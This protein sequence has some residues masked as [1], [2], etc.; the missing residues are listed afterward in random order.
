M[1][2]A[3]AFL[4]EHAGAV[5]ALAGPCALVAYKVVGIVHCSYTC[6]T[7]SN[8]AWEYSQVLGNACMNAYETA[9]WPLLPALVF[10]TIASWL[11]LGVLAVAPSLRKDI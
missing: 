9:T 1:R 2:K 4:R 10:L 5:L 8:G 7:L 3:T 6:C 11:F